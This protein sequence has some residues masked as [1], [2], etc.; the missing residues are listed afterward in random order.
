[1]KKIGSEIPFPLHLRD[2]LTNQMPQDVR[3]ISEDLS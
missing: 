2:P 1:M 3:I